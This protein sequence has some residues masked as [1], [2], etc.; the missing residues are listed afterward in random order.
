MSSQA[1]HFPSEITAL[2]AGIGIDRSSCL[3]S[4]NP[5]LDSSQLL[6][7]CGRQEL[8]HKPYDRIHPIILHGKHPLARLIVRAEHIR[9]MHSGPTLIIANLSRQFHIIGGRKIVRS[10]IRQCIHCSKVSAIPLTPK[11]GNLPIE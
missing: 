9:L 11:M 8:S 3:I 6:R 4:L 10:I 2:Q 5:L 1:D 7:V